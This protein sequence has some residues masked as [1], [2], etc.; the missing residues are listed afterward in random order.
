M[1]W[2]KFLSRK[3]Y[4]QPLWKFILEGIAIYTVAIVVIDSLL[5]LLFHR[6]SEPLMDAL[7]LVT[8][9][10]FIDILAFNKSKKK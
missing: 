8:A 4:D 3:N 10:T 1:N 2:K 7:V 9:F 6:K 5:S